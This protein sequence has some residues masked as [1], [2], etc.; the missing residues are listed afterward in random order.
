VCK[1]CDG[2]ASLPLG[3]GYSKGVWWFLGVRVDNRLS[4]LEEANLRR[5][6][7]DYFTCI[8][9]IESALC[10]LETDLALRLILQYHGYQLFDEG[11]CLIDEGILEEEEEE[12]E[13]EENEL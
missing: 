1:L 11:F 8:N 3:G 4:D 12:E 6:G 2:Q 5:L 9:T 13:E 7:V 10:E